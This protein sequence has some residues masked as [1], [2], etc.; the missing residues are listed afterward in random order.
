MVFSGIS[1]VPFLSFLL[2]VVYINF[3]SGKK[4][5]FSKT[6]LGSLINSVAIF[7]LSRFSVT[8]IDNLQDSRGWEWSIFIL[9]YFFH[10][11]TNIQ[12]LICNFACQMTTRLYL[13]DFYLM[14]FTKEKKEEN[15]KIVITVFIK[16][17]ILFLV[18]P[19]F[20]NQRVQFQRPND[21]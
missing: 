1:H 6:L 17:K 20:S 12:T 7:L 14:R 21:E 11:L 18:Q 5:L 15:R 19:C 13:P 4:S 16:G 8:D 2:K 10:P 9:L 3:L